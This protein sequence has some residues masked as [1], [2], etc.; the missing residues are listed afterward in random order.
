MNKRLHGDY[1]MYVKAVKCSL[2]GEPV[3]LKISCRGK[4]Y[5]IC[6]DCRVQLF[7]RGQ[8]GIDRILRNAFVIEIETVDGEGVEGS[9]VMCGG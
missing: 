1:A 9:E 8:P 2:C 6:Q 4:P 7:T 5:Y 3:P